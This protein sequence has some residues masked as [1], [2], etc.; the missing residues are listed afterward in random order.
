MR[1][2]RP[3]ESG[4]ASRCRSRCA[5][6][7]S[8]RRPAWASPLRDEND[9]NV[10]FETMIRDADTAMYQAKDAGRD[11]IAVFDQSMRARAAERLELEHNL[12]GAHE[13]GELEVHFQPIVTLP[14]GQA[15]GVEALVRWSHPLLGRIPPAKVHPSP[16]TWGSSPS[17]VDGCSTRRVASWPSGARRSPTTSELYAVN[18]SARQ[19]RDPRLMER[20]LARG[21]EQPAAA[22]AVPRAHRALAHE[23]RGGRRCS[24]ISTSSGSGCRSTT[25]GPA[26]RRSRT[27][28]VPDRLREDRPR[29]RRGARSG[30]RR[31]EPRRR[32]HRDGRCPRH[33]HDRRR[34]RD[35]RAVHA[36]SHRARLQRRPGQLLFASDPDGRPSQPSSISSASPAAHT[37]RSC[38]IPNLPEPV[39]QTVHAV[40]AW[41]PG[42]S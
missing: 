8:I 7:R 20:V 15:L 29:L 25:S 26:S 10:D 2:S 23:H 34:R 40:C 12:R 28:A 18:L 32:D 9:P 4:A 6:R 36:R 11:G 41:P 42:C 30:E 19:L 13:R 33:D 3:S 31:R 1:S 35:V 37:S 24:T 21:A 17:S 14:D 39:G 38:R 27:S 16:R 5:R 22:C